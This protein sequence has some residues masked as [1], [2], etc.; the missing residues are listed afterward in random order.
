MRPKRARH[1]RNKPAKFFTGNLHQFQLFGNKRKEQP[2]EH[3]DANSTECCRTFPGRGRARIRY[4]DN[5][6]KYMMFGA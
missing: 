4:V 1:L 2:D 6:F 3:H 5:E